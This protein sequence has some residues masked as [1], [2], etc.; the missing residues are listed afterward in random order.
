M[1]TSHFA[2]RTSVTMHPKEALVARRER[3]LSE[4]GHGVAI[5][6]TAP[7]AVRSNDTDYK[8]RPDTDFY[9][10]TGFPEPEAVAVFAP[11]HKEHT[12]VLFVRPRDPEK[13]VWDGRRAGV[14]GAVERYGADAAF[15]I[16]ELEER[17][18]D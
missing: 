13:E 18:F 7:V 6:P 16:A 12:F 14:E 5:I 9:Y 2:P 1:R 11:E 4:M 10:L 8:F 15:P 3:F 17:I